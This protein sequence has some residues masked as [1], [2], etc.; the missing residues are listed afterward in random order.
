MTALP[1]TDVTLLKKFAHE[2]PRATKGYLEKISY[3][4]NSSYLIINDVSLLNTNEE[5]YHL[6]LQYIFLSFTKCSASFSCMA[7]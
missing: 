6:N 3:C 2:I 1:R 7:F 5:K 4:T